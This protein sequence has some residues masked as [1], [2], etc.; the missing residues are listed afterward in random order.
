MRIFLHS[1]YFAAVSFLLG[2]CFQITEIYTLNPEG[3]GKVV[4][5][6]VFPVTD[7]G[8]EKS[9]DPEIKL[10]EEILAELKH[11]K[12]VEA[13][14]E[15]S[16]KYE[17]KDKIYFK[18]TAYFKDLSKLKFYNFGIKTTFLD[19][20]IFSRK[21]G[22]LSIELRSSKTAEKNDSG[23]KK[24]EEKHMLAL[25]EAEVKQQ[26][27]ESKKEIIKTKMMLAGLLS[28]L[29]IERT[30]YLPG[31]IAYSSNFERN[32]D[33][34]VRNNFAGAR[35]LELITAKLDDEEWLRQ[36]IRIGRDVEEE[37]LPDKYNVNGHL[38]GQ[39]TPVR[40][41]MTKT[42]VPLFDYEKEIAQ[43]KINY[44]NFLA[45]LEPLKLPAPIKVDPATIGKFSVAGI[46]Y[47]A[48][49]DV[50]NG[51]Q[52]L[53]YRRGYTLAIM[54]ILQEQA[55][56]LLPGK[57][58]TALTDTGISLLPES[59]R[60]REISWPKLG[61]DGRTVLLELELKNPGQKV[62][63]LQKLSG[64]LDYLVSAGEFNM[65]D[66]GISKFEKGVEG[67]KFGAKVISAG[68]DSFD[69]LVDV[70]KDSIKSAKLF[71]K[72]DNKVDAICSYS[73]SPTYTI[74]KFSPMQQG[75]QLPLEGKVQLEI[76]A[77]FKV[78]ELEFELTDIPLFGR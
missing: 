31:T 19:L 67:H 73:W 21:E 1:L 24:I 47:I 4:Y 65:V 3:S 62:K 46:R 68:V 60:D 2:G 40:V 56:K 8:I 57:L 7:L 69:I 35:L 11:A 20:I 6:A 53:G 44:Q 45:K 39:K 55:R 26:L 49:D 50:E 32:L 51:I 22:R 78:Y 36:Q 9:I 48:F 15:V 13:W 66:L 14:D 30:F 77:D 33:G 23:E 70:V 59:D 10:K 61:K 64:T 41:V 34:S 25:T 52:P 54:G 72:Q 18:G 42:D 27:V 17:G 74:L 76:L 71:D 12:G 37:Y 75:Q 43:V 28:D 38:F 63:S 29:K 58:E 16:Y 5:E